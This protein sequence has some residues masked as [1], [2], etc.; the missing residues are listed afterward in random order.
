MV[1]TSGMYVVFIFLLNSTGLDQAFSLV[2]PISRGSAVLYLLRDNNLKRSIRLLE[3]SSFFMLGM[4]GKWLFSEHGLGFSPRSILLL[5]LNG[6]LFGFVH[7]QYAG[8]LMSLIVVFALGISFGFS[9][10]KMGLITSIIFHATW[11][12]YLPIR[13]PA[14]IFFA[15]LFAIYWLYENNILR[16][17]SLGYSD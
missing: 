13:W 4:F 17:K 7:V 11:N 3:R 1:Q 9:F 15:G 6:L 14:I 2:L 16:R 12:T 5:M 8:D 10:A